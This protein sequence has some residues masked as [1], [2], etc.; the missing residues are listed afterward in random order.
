MRWGGGEQRSVDPTCLSLSIQ[1][2]AFHSQILGHLPL[3]AII[4]LI[5]R[6]MGLACLLVGQMEWW[7]LAVSF[8][9][10]HLKR[11]GPCGH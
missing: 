1:L 4:R 3:G 9:K 11:M 6:A 8:K 7:K 2:L 5:L 10:G